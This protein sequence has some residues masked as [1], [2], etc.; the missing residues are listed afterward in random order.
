MQDEFKMLEERM[1]KY[2]HLE[3]SDEFNLL[4]SELYNEAIEKII[5]ATNDN[6]TLLA[7]KQ[8]DSVKLITNRIKLARTQY[9]T[10]VMAIKNN[11]D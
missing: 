11:Q 3:Q 2:N 8:L 6:D 5:A 10:E 4:I 1:L 7:K 9:E